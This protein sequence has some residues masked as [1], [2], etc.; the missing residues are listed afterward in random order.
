MTNKYS[1]YELW[2]KFTLKGSIFQSSYGNTDAWFVF[3]NYESLWSETCSEFPFTTTVRRFD[4]YKVF[5][6]DVN[7][8]SSFFHAEN[9]D[10]SVLIILVTCQ[11]YL[12]KSVFQSPYCLFFSGITQI[13]TSFFLA[14]VYIVL[15]FDNLETFILFIMQL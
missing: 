3:G 2:D 11:I 1:L 4:K 15:L 6:Y 14:L 7:S 12:K 8:V 10:Q 9:N 5:F 13:E